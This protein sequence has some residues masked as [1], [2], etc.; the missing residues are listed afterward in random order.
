MIKWCSH[1]TNP[2]KILIKTAYSNSLVPSQLN[3]CFRHKLQCSS[4]TYCKYFSSC[5]KVDTGLSLFSL[6]GMAKEKWEPFWQP[7]KHSVSMLVF[8]WRKIISCLRKCPN[9]GRLILQEKVNGIQ[10][11]MVIQKES[12]QSNANKHCFS[13]LH[14]LRW[15]YVIK[16]EWRLRGLERN[17]LNCLLCSCWHCFG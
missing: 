11:Y 10:A 15:V 1:T 2:I 4:S 9:F 8:R 14:F 3:C 13:S 12:E 6:E 16:R 5:N 7:F 17:E